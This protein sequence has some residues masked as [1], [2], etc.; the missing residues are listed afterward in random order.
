M[1]ILCGSGSDSICVSHPDILMKCVP[2]LKSGDYKAAC[3]ILAGVTW[4]PQ[5]NCQI[6]R[7]DRRLSDSPSLAQPESKDAFDEPL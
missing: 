6:L 7:S 3:G 5:E 4:L 1:R 2:C